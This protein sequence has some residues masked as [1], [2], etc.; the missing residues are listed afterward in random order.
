MSNTYTLVNPHI[1]GSMNTTVKAD[2]SFKAGKKL[3]SALSEHFNNNV[4]HFY[5][6]I[7]KGGSGKGKYYHFKVSEEK[8]GNEINF[9][10][11]QVDLSNEKECMKKFQGKLKNYLKKQ[12]GGKKHDDDDLFDDKEP[13]NI[14]WAPIVYWWYD[15]IIYSIDYVFVPTFYSTITPFVELALVF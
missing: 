13:S 1:E 7:Q 9:D 3:Y 6:T 15:P 12:T 8:N 5:F 4:P 2:N 14:S 10:L 11:E